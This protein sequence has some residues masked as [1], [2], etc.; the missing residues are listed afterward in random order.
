MKVIGINGSPRREWNTAQMVES[1]LKGAQAAGAETTLYHLRDIDFKGCVSCFACLKLGAPTHGRCS[2][3]DALK[4]VIDD[5]LSAD[6]LIIGSPVYFG[7]ITA[8]TRAL[9]E[10]LWFGGLA[11]DMSHFVLYTRQIPVKVIFT[12]NAPQEGFHTTLN[13]SVVTTM[14]RFIGPTELI[15]ANDTLQFDDYSK[16]DAA[17]FNVAA[18]QKRHEEHF[19]LDLQRAFDVG[20]KAVGEAAAV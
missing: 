1:A 17:M 3:P 6:A 4:P 13:E 10:R 8:A 7:D 9:L 12:T 11:Y 2:Y 5:I 20:K 18:K 14:S 19:P 15:E 16:Y